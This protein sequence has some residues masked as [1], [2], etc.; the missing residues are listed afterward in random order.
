MFACGIRLYWVPTIGECG[1]PTNVAFDVMLAGDG[2][3]G[4]VLGSL[5]FCRIPEGQPPK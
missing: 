4:K 2:W 1:V 3:A 5:G